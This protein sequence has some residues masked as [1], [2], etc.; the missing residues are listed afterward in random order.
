MKIYPYIYLIAALLAVSNPVS[1][2][3][4][5]TTLQGNVILT[6]QAELDLFWQQNP[7]I[8]IDTITGDLILAGDVVDISGFMGLRYIGGGIFA[9]GSL[10]RSPSLRGLDS[11]REIDDFLIL[12]TQVFDLDALG[13]LEAVGRDVDNLVRSGLTKSITFGDGSYDN[14]DALSN[15]RIAHQCSFSI[16][17]CD[18]RD[19][20]GIR[21]ISGLRSLSLGRAEIVIFPDLPYVDTL[22]RLFVSDVLGLSEL[23]LSGLEYV[24][25]IDIRSNIN[26]K[27]LTFNKPV[28]VGKR[29]RVPDDQFLD[30]SGAINISG[31]LECLTADFRR[32]D[33]LDFLEVR[34]SSN[35]PFINTCPLLDFSRLP[36]DKFTLSKS[37]AGDT[38]VLPFISPD[39]QFTWGT[40]ERHRGFSR[41]GVEY[42]LVGLSGVRHL[43]IPDTGII[44]IENFENLQS[45]TLDTFANRGQLQGLV[46]E[47]CESLETAALF[48]QIHGSVMNYDRELTSSI[49]TIG[50]IDCINLELDQDN[51]SSVDSTLGI[52]LE[53]LPSARV[54]PKFNNLEYVEDFRLE[55]VPVHDDTLFS[56][57]LTIEHSLFLEFSPDNPLNGHLHLNYNTDKDTLTTV[58]QFGSYGMLL[59]YGGSDVSLT[60][61]NEVTTTAGLFVSGVHGFTLDASNFLSNLTGV[62]YYVFGGSNSGV[63]PKIGKIDHIFEVA[64]RADDGTQYTRFNNEQFI[65]VDAT[66]ITDATAVCPLINSGNYQSLDLDPSNSYP[67]HD[68]AALVSYCDSNRVSNTSTL[69]QWKAFA[70]YPTLNT[71]GGTVNFKGLEKY[72][73]TLQYR[74]LNLTGQEQGRGRLVSGSYGR[75]DAISLPGNLPEGQYFLDVLDDRGRRGTS[76]IQIVKR[77]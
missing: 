45:I 55:N 57:N 72:T 27:S 14:F 22:H 46:I 65:I 60:G 42:R 18:V 75:I 9:P 41:H 10:S 36:M 24:N 1:A 7:G 76:V 16:S 37:Y 54:L 69:G 5:C 53:N 12:I 28:Y 8:C 35:S 20:S 73:G 38:L 48:D 49:T 59:D 15:L 70:A 13:K 2:Q 39:N 6:S 33:S 52:Q 30:D 25:E 32:A 40:G 63:L 71:S 21:N 74:I 68:A 11:L 64:F 34:I 31:N 50:V 44:V 19:A 4:S 77:P 56:D 51:F 47:D 26:L 23:T 17:N 58:G 43:V 3:D 61:L 29:K 62:N 66:D 67:L